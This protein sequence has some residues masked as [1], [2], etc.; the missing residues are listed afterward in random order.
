M[1]RCAAALALLGACSFATQSAEPRWDGRSEPPECSD[2]SVTFDRA[3]GA[4]LGI[5]GVTTI[6]S[7]PSNEANVWVGGVAIG[8][9]L[10]YW[11][12]AASG[13]KAYATCQM[14]RMRW[15]YSNA[16]KARDP[17][18]APA[19]APAVPPPARGA[20]PAPQPM[21]G[22]GDDARPW[23]RGVPEEEQAIALQLF[24]A[25][26]REFIQA[27]YPQA[28]LK[29]R[30]AIPHWDHPAIRYNLAVCLFNLG[31]LVE[32]RN[33][34]ERSMAYG[35]AVLGADKYAQAEGYRARLDALLV[36]LTLDCPEPG[37]QVMVDGE[38]VFTG[39]GAVEIFVLPGEHNIVAT[40]PGFLPATRKV[41]LAAGQPASYEIRPFVDPR[42]AGP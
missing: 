24:E 11:L 4:G 28:L 23:A 17:G 13:S 6:T 25:G 1:T 19:S 2:T 22:P 16:I 9:G 35:P 18:S 15:S 14:A 32:A 21:P 39:P 3:A 41:V 38:L 8:L 40:K 36:R 7:N 29:Y 27:H 34:F 31:R 26:N 5:A 33:H 20:G 30:E 42:P 37:E 10:V 12:S